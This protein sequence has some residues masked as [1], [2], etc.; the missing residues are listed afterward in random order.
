MV[1]EHAHE[2]DV[3]L[4]LPHS[5]A[6]CAHREGVCYLQKYLRR[7]SLRSVSDVVRRS[8]GGRSGTASKQTNFVSGILESRSKPSYVRF[9]ATLPAVPV[10]YNQDPHFFTILRLN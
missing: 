1:R 2:R 7:N 4:E 9:S 6:D 8:I 10:G 5:S 3:R